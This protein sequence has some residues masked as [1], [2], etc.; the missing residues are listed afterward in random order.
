[1][2]GK[3]YRADLQDAAEDKASIATAEAARIAKHRRQM[4]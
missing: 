2:N 3:P 4:T 1:M